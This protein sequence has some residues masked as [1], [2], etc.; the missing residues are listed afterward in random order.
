MD[1]KQIGLVDCNGKIK[2]F[3]GRESRMDPGVGSTAPGRSGTSISGPESR[4]GQGS[5]GRHD[6]GSS[7]RDSYEVIAGVRTVGGRRRRDEGCH[8][9]RSFRDIT[10]ARSFMLRGQGQAFTGG[11]ADVRHGGLD[12]TPEAG[13]ITGGRTLPPRISMGG[14]NPGAQQSCDPHSGTTSGVAHNT[15]PLEW[16]S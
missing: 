2:D 6:P 10:G 13:H 5:A 16:L 7:S 11:G 14:H 3:L 4:G 12:S 9:T 1:S 8:G 15:G